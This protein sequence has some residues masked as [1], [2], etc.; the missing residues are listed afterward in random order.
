VVCVAATLIVLPNFA[1]QSRW[2]NLIFGPLALVLSALWIMVA[3]GATAEPAR[4]Q[5]DAADP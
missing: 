3:R 5:A 1:S 2:E 4:G